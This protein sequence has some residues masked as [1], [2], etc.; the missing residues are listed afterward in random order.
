MTIP[1]IPISLSRA[2]Y[3]PGIIFLRERTAAP[4][5][6]KDICHSFDNKLWCCV[7]FCFPLL[8]GH[9]DRE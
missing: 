3:E 5:I 9:P 4:D 7:R 6:I 8:A 2:T 1:D